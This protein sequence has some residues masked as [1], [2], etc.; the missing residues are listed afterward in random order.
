MHTALTKEGVGDSEA[1]ESGSEPDELVLE[2]CVAEK[3]AEGEVGVVG[4][5][6]ADVAAGEELHGRA[7][8][9]DGGASG[10]DAEGEAGLNADDQS[11]QN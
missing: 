2:G 9:G 6:G 11:E 3:G 4:L 7:D 10:E 8:E 1:T 5:G